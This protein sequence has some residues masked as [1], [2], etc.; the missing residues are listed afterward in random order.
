VFFFLTLRRIVFV[1]R[2][3]QQKR[4][5]KGMMAVI[6]NLPTKQS[7]AEF[8]LKIKVYINTY[9]YQFGVVI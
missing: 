1:I 2:V 6:E 5:D 3:R 8:Y 4:A 9:L 7:Y